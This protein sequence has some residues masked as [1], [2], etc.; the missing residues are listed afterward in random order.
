MWWKRIQVICT[1]GYSNILYILYFIFMDQI[2][3]WRK[4]I[5]VIC[6]IGFS[7][8]NSNFPQM[9]RFNIFSY[10]NLGQFSVFIL[11]DFLGQIN[12]HKIREMMKQLARMTCK[13][14]NDNKRIFFAFFYFET[15]FE[16]GSGFHEAAD[17]P[18][19]L[20]CDL[21]IRAFSVPQPDLASVSVKLA[22]N[23]I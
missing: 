2:H 15:T 8:S 1:I 11:F 6:T 18:F 20:Q 7:S 23:G 21:V 19:L 10:F 5:Q 17:K 13:I 22:G 14:L 12:R 9:F 4:R 3:M 16:G